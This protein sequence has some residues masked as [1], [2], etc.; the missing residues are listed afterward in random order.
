MTNKRFYFLMI[1]LN[2]GVLLLI[3]FTV[4]WGNNLIEKQSTKLKEAKTQSQLIEQQQVYLNQ[5]KKDVEKYKPLNEVVK[6]VV[7][8]DKDQAKTVRE[9]TKIASESGIVL[10]NVSFQTSNL[11]QT[12]TPTPS[13]TTDGSTAQKPA[14]PTLSQVKPID[15]IKDV[16]ALEVTISNAENNTISYPQFIKFLE[17]LENNRR[18]AHV[19]KILVKPSDDGSSIG[20]TLTLNAYVK[21]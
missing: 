5:A 3:F 20:F 11:G 12:T 19:D 16:F 15:G 21:P 4:F 17:R 6:S 14:A 7:P 13:T 9:I 10:Q 2:A 8:Q 1:G 18:T